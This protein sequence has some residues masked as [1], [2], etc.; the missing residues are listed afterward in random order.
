MKRK[1]E[2]VTHCHSLVFCNGGEN[3][4]I[5]DNDDNNL[6]DIYKQKE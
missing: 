5:K 3:G 1:Y 6:L 4:W 2:T